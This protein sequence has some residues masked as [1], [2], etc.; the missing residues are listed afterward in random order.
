MEQDLLQPKPQSKV[1][2]NR[3]I[4]IGTFLGGPLVAG[5]LIAEN[6]KSFGESEKVKT[7][8][9]YTIV[10]SMIIFA[11]GYALKNDGNLTGIIFT[12]IYTGCASTIARMLQE[13][14]INEHIQNGG[15]I[16]SNWRAALAG[17]VGFIVTVAIVVLI[18]LIPRLQ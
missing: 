4:W 2:K 7:T 11:I 8:W 9:A 17:L 10:A 13:N 12:L 1:F 6:F 16:Y 3:A 5:Y 14:Q 18:I 15:E